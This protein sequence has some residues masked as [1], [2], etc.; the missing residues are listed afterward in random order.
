MNKGLTGKLGQIKGVG[1]RPIESTDML[2]LEKLYRSTREQELDQTGWYEQQKVE[3]I[4][5][6][7]HAQHRFYQENYK[8][9]FFEIIRIDDV[10]AGRLY[11]VEWETE[12]RIIDIALLPEFRNNGW[13]GKILSEIISVARQQGKSLGIHVE[14]NNPARSLYNRLGFVLEEDKGVYQFL[15][16]HHS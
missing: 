16:W 12:I 14:F 9:A 13:G 15:M 1:F 6:Q 10:P 7:F 8:G 11:L 5:Q 3:F 2:F 4:R